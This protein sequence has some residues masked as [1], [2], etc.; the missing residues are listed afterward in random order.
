[1][2]KQNLIKTFRRNF[3]TKFYPSGERFVAKPNLIWE[4]RVASDRSVHVY[5]VLNN[6]QF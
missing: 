3:E 1:M 4:D 6:E 5:K 2:F